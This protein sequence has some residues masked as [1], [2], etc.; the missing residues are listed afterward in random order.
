MNKT[1]SA[2]KFI[3]NVK[4]EIALGGKLSV[5]M[6]MLNAKIIKIFGLFVTVLP[7]MCEESIKIDF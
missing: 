6:S 2:H 1:Y 5:I 4:A 3:E 7:L